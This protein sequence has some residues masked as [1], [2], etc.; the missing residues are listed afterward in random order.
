M[1]LS[2]VIRRVRNSAGDINA[3]QFTD[4]MLYDWVNDAIKECA[5]QNQLFQKSA[6]QNTVAGTADYSLPTD[7]F[8]LHSVVVNSAKLP[9]LT[10]QQWEELNAGPN[11]PAATNSEPVQCYVWAGKITLFPTPDK[12]YTLKVN[13]L[14]EPAALTAANLADQLPLPLA[15]HNRVVTYCLA[16]AALLDE[17]LIKYQNMMTMFTTG[18]IDLAANTQQEED[19][20]PFIS[21]GT[22][23]MGYY[24]SSLEY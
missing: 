15:Y 3:L 9:V 20:Y 12:A 22:R 13:Y 5:L 17:D 4:T 11:P 21:T 8:K 23:D 2:D 1:L 10:L 19:L 7:I 6:T 16:Q 24:D 14:Y 18:V